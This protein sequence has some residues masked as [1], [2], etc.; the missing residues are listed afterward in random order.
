MD[1]IIATSLLA[2][3]IL[4]ATSACIA[5]LTLP[6]PATRTALAIRVASALLLANAG[7]LVATLASGGTFLV[8]VTQH[9]IYISTFAI[10]PVLMRS[11]Y[12][13]IRGVIDSHN[14][15]SRS[16]ESVHFRPRFS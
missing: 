16:S 11:A 10:T 7:I 4:L 9:T 1:T 5:P 8:F 6:S 15:E 2:I 14:Y 12:T 3:G 13:A